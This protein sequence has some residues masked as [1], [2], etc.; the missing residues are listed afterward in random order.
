MLNN[1]TNYPGKFPCH[2]CKEVVTNIRSWHET[3]D[4]TWRCSKGHISKVCLRP[5]KKTKKDYQSE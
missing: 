5:I 4:V 3:G 1:F 2:T